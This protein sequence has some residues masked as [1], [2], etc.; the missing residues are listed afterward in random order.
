MSS[1]ML[2]IRF[3]RGCRRCPSS[4]PKG[5]VSS[6][7]RQ[8]GH[9]GFSYRRSA[10]SSNSWA[11][12]LWKQ[13]PHA[14]SIS[15]TSWPGPGKGKGSMHTVH[16][17]GPRTRDRVPQHAM[18]DV[19]SLLP[20]STRERCGTLSAKDDVVSPLSS[21]QKQVARRYSPSLD[22]CSAPPEET[23]APPPTTSA[24]DPPPASF[25]RAGGKGTCS[26]QR[27]R[28]NIESLLGEAKKVTKR[29]SRA[30]RR[31]SRQM[32]SRPL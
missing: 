10:F 23:R 7:A 14:C 11:Q 29:M 19:S 27:R 25:A 21:V 8:L 2:A 28:G 30:T 13:W 5:A 17:S 16:I 15:T 22:E 24:R 3:F 12:S 20:V 26:N 9:R 1:R 6:V 18:P 32:R 31:K 4:L